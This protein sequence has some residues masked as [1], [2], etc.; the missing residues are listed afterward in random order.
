M[1]AS[2]AS[3]SLSSLLC[4]EDEASILKI[5]D[6]S[7][8][9]DCMNPCFVFDN[10]EEYIEILLKREVGFLALAPSGVCSLSAAK[11]LKSSRLDAIHWIFSVS[12]HQW[13]F[14]FKKFLPLCFCFNEF[15]VSFFF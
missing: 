8:G 2:D 6:E 10:E 4:E 3:F 1:A 9:L 15:M 5:G 14:P 13:N 7:S 11:W 12:F